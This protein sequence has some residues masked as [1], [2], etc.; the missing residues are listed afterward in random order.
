M[1]NNKTLAIIKPDSVIKN[2][3][4]KI[5]DRILSAEF[6]IAAMEQRELSNNDAKTFYKI[7]KERPFFED[8]VSFMTSGPCVPIVLKK[9]NAVLSFRNLIGSTNPEE[10]DFGTIRKDFAENVQNNAV[11]GSDSDENAIKEI[12][13]FFPTF[14]I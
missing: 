14:E 13:F 4:G 6:I 9:N 1:L 5:I 7:H 2:N 11:H 3:T 10:A 12:A 8:L